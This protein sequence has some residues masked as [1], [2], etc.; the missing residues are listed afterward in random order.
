MQGMVEIRID[1]SQRQWLGIGLMLNG[2]Y[3]LEVRR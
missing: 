1:Q 3:A 2:R